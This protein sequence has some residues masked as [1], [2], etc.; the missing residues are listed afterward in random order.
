MEKKNLEYEGLKIH[1]FPDF[2]PS[3]V[4]RRA[5]FTKV[6]EI[7][8]GRPGVR[9]R[10]MYPARLMVTHGNVKL[11]FTDPKEAQDYAERHFGQPL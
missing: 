10:L 11:S 7:L 1:I 4:K 6:R 8:R 5:A 9:Y 3:V 2:P